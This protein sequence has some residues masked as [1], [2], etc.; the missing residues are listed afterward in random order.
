MFAKK[1][2]VDLG[3][4][5]TRIFVPRHGVVLDEPTVVAMDV[6]TNKVVAIGK[7]AE[8]ML[9]RTPESIE[10]YRPLNDGVIADFNI[11]Q[12]ML[13]HHLTN[14]IGRL[15][16]V[17]PDI[18]I[19]LPGGA[20]STERKAVVDVALAAGGRAAYTIPQT[21]AAALGAYVPIAEAA[22]SLVIDFGGGTAEIAVLSLGSV[23]AQHSLREGGNKLDQA[24]AE[25]I[26]KNHGLSI[27]DQTAEIV[28]RKVASALPIK[29]QLRVKV[30]GRDLSGGLPKTATVGSD[31]LVEVIQDCAERLVLAVRTVLEDTSPEL[32]SD[33]VDRGIIISGGSAKLR[34]LDKLLSKVIGVPVV[35]A[36]RPLLC[37][38]RGMGVAL[39]SLSDYQ[40]SLVGS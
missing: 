24:V 12:I 23:V 17:K 13:K 36:A 29:K 30:K 32:V 9:G 38:I 34:N 18:M 5:N 25:H 26:R 2:A 27:G 19:S 15:N 4:V 31:E 39:H 28:K 3:T 22:G 8:A 16:I 14:A 10:L 6:N 1:I 35:V 20:T 40:K 7:A 33:I 11:T 21:V 37:T